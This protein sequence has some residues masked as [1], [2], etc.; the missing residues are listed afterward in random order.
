MK[1]VLMA[2]FAG[3]LTL[4]CMT[5]N[6]HAE[7]SE[8]D[9]SEEIRMFQD[10]YEHP[11]TYIFQDGEGNDITAFVLEQKDSFHRDAYQTTDLLMDTVKSVQEEAPAVLTRAASKSKT[12]SNLKVYFQKNRY[13]IYS[14]TGTYSISSGKITNGKAVPKIVDRKNLSYNISYIGKAISKNGKTIT[15]SI[16]HIM[17]ANSK[18]TATTKHTISI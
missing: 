6:V 16:K 14:V 13:C 1:K 5:G 4:S 7:E 2:L 17:I 11:D 10:F 9:Y 3:F 18:V 12:W 15:Y 8:L